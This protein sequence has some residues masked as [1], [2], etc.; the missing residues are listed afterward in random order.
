MLKLLRLIKPNSSVFNLMRVC[1]KE[2]YFF[3]L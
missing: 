1:V 2:L 3:I